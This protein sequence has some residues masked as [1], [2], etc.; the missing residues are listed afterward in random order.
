MPASNRAPWNETDDAE[1]ISLV[2]AETSRRDTAARLG[3]SQEATGA[4]IM[5]LKLR[6]LM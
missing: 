4:R 2:R 6:G 1:L 5:R 3:R